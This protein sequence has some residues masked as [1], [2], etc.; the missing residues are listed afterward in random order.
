[1]SPDRGLDK[2]LDRAVV[3]GYT[4]VGYALRRR[5]WPADDP[6]PNALVGRRAVVT[7]AGG[8]LGEATALGLARLGATVHLVVRSSDRAM[9]AVGR[10]RATLDAEGRVPDLRVEECDVADPASVRAFSSSFAKRLRKAGASLDLLVHNAGVMPAERTTSVDGHELT[11]ATHVLGPVRMTEALRPVLRTSDGGARVVLVSSGGQ[12]AQ[13]LD[14]DDVEFEQRA[15][16]PPSAYAHS[17]RIQV[18]LAATLAER[19]ASDSVA[20]Y[21][22]HP[23]WADTPGVASSMP[24]FRM[25]TRPLLRSTE[26]GAD[27]IVWLCATEPEPP[28]GTFWHDRQERP[29]TFF[30][31]GVASADDVERVWREVKQ[32]TGLR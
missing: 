8:G 6:A 17:K 15:Y 16:K 32:A 10:I 9:D 31:A 26:A 18:E 1:M 7:G 5:T 12:Y 3:P 30:G 2:L 23:G 27:T 13:P 20:V 14:A 22:M 4:N 11:L 29:I 19:W 25:V 28:S 24:L 21:A